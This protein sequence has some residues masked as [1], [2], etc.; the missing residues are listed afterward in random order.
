MRVNAWVL[1]ASFSL[2]LLGCG[3]GGSDSNNGGGG[4]QNPVQVPLFS[5][6]RVADYVTTDLEQGLANSAS[7]TGDGAATAI[8]VIPFSFDRL[9]AFQTAF[10]L[11]APVFDE[12]RKNY[13]NTGGFTWSFTYQTATYTVSYALSGN[14]Q[15]SYTVRATGTVNGVDVTNQVIAS[16]QVSQ[17]TRDNEDAWLQTIDA[18][19][20]GSVAW[21]GG[22]YDFDGG[23]DEYFL[24]AS[25]Q[26]QTFTSVWL[27]S[28]A[29]TGVSLVLG[30][31]LDSN[32]VLLDGAVTAMDQGIDLTVYCPTDLL[33]AVVDL[34]WSN[35]GTDA[36]GTALAG[37]ACSAGITQNASFSW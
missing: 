7:A 8:A 30:N 32:D 20:P 15:F 19:V 31:D 27:R 3:G 26:G 12:A 14:N 23:T 1:I 5:G 28:Q 25:Y 37:T 2:I 4:D 13:P 36:T 18:D 24:T 33:A 34:D 16:G 29:G 6:V 11:L 10:N 35:G 21:T 9:I 22:I 17:V